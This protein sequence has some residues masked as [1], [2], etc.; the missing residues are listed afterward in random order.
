MKQQDSSSDSNIRS[1]SLW[2][3]CIS[4]SQISGAAKCHSR[5]A[6]L[7]VMKPGM[8][9]ELISFLDKEMRAGKSDLDV[10]GV[11][12]K[13]R[14]EALNA[15]DKKF[16]TILT[17][18]IPNQSDDTAL[19]FTPDGLGLTFW[20]DNPDIQESDYLE[21][22]FYPS[23]TA[24]W[25]VHCYV[26]VV[27]IKIDKNT[28]LT[29]VSCQFEKNVGPLLIPKQKRIRK[30]VKVEELVKEKIAK[31]VPKLKIPKLSKPKVSK[32]VKSK[33]KKAD[34][35]VIKPETVEKVAKKTK[36][37]EP[38]GDSKFDSLL[39]KGLDLASKAD[40]AAINPEVKKKV[41]DKNND[42]ASSDRKDFRINDRIPFIW[43]VVSEETFKKECMPHFESHREFGLRSRIKKQQLLLKEFPDYFKEMQ[44]I[45]SKARKYIVWIYSK[46]SWLFLRAGNENEEEY[47][48]GVTNIFLDITK[49]LSKPLGKDG[50]H[51][52]QIL[53][54]FKAQIE[55]QIIRDQAD[56]IM[57]E[58]KLEAAKEALATL[59]KANNKII[60]ELEKT[61]P[62][63]STN[64]K[65]FKGLLDDI[66]LTM[67]D[68]PVGVSD[69]GKDLFTVNLSLTGLAFRTYRKGI[70]KGDLLEMRI[71]LSTGG[72][73]F[74]P[75]NCFGRV[76]FVQGPQDNK[77]K[78]ATHID[79]MPQTFR[80]KINVHVARRQR[81]KLAELAELKYEAQE[82]DK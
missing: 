54:Q 2:W 35:A 71:F 33:P 26:R 80:Q 4:A 14:M 6:H 43:S 28:E 62:K 82:N 69:D 30:E 79:P 31:I 22:Q 10:D 40:K 60:L 15:L 74:D 47:F 76:V 45:R 11:R 39:K 58:A 46:L 25:P 9:Q 7:P 52:V 63:L 81:E 18:V 72:E 59:D 3:R 56:P 8:Q 23:T 61:N 12:A 57:D 48:Q 41:E 77:Y 13:N 73:R 67:L 49:T 50:R 64:L 27:G 68:R 38:K 55:N 44:K 5:G 42:K 21:V 17:A 29:R 36:T 34:D 37:K 51:I 65:M 20:L 24:P 70:K 66:N 53:S 16:T 1:V 32:I 75:V 19:R 78:I